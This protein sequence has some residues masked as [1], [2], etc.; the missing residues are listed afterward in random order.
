[1]SSSKR[2][3]TIWDPD[4]SVAKEYLAQFDTDFLIER[5]YEI[6]DIIGAA[7]IKELARLSRE[8]RARNGKEPFVKFVYTDDNI[9]QRFYDTYEPRTL[10]S[11][12]KEEPCDTLEPFPFNFNEEIFSVQE[13]TSLVSS[14]IKEEN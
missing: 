1:M 13:P 10:L 7:N 6:V 9:R 4:P 11:E 8:L 3:P 14:Q 5:Y 2:P 12:M